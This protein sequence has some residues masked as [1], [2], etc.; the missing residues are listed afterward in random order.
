M[1]YPKV[2]TDTINEKLPDE[3]A[4]PRKDR[5]LV[6][7]AFRC[8]VATVLSMVLCGVVLGKPEIAFASYAAFALSAMCDFD[9]TAKERTTANVVATA[10]GVLGVVLGSAVGF[11]YGLSIVAMFVVAFGFSFARLFH[12][13]IAR[14]AVGV[15]LGFILAVVTPDAWSKLGPNTAA[16]ALGCGVSTLCGLVIL[17]RHHSTSVRRA[18]SQWCKAAAELTRSLN[19]VDATPAAL[20]KLRVHRDHLLMLAAGTQDWPGSL[21]KRQR[22]LSDL[23]VV[24]ESGTALFERF[25]KTPL[26]H[27]THYEILGEQTARAFEVA[28]QTVLGKQASPGSPWSEDI[29]DDLSIDYEDSVAWTQEGLMNDPQHA[30]DRIEQHHPLRVLAVMADVVQRYALISMGASVSPPRFAPTSRTTPVSLLRANFSWNS[31]WF[32]N[33]LRAGGAMA[34]A[35]GIERHF[36]LAHGFWVV[37]AALSIVNATFTRHDASKAAVDATLGIFLGVVVGG[38]LIELSLPAWAFL[39]LIPIAIF[40]SKWTTGAGPILGN[41][42]FALYSVTVFSYIGWPPQLKVAE[43]RFEWA[44]IGISVALGLTFLAFPRGHS[45]LVAQQ[46]DLS[47]ELADQ[48]V[49]SAQELLVNR[50]SNRAAFDMQLSECMAQVQRFIDLL[51]STYH[52]AHT[53]P[54]ELKRYLE[55]ES[56]LLQ[57]ILVSDT[58]V[59]YLEHGYTGLGDAALNAV[60][61]APPTYRLEMLRD[62]VNKDPERLSRHPRILLSAVW[63]AQWLHDLERER[64][65]DF[66][67]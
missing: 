37:L 14:S 35:I 19:V 29:W 4:L 61:Q 32:R 24:A 67:S 48:L 51:E 42:T 27:D 6:R 31:I 46:R 36:D 1:K 5:V 21:F 43:T 18:I 66:V 7:S 11:S 3:L 54:P 45:R 56:W 55:D 39:I 57:A 64:P 28:E 44:L 30:L 62:L 63:S 47:Y 2:T 41:A 34:V 8:T 38:L 53:L 52:A 59:N 16:W 26:R 9:G 23:Y 50:A 40:A 15:Q 17:P 58:M 12:G 10:V 65:K 22:A 20:E 25:D 60:F 33:A 13:F 49:V